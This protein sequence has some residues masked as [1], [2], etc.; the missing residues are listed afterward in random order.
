MMQ[1]DSKVPV[2]LTLQHGSGRRQLFIKASPSGEQEDALQI[3]GNPD[4]PDLTCY[5][6]VMARVS[7]MPLRGSDSEFHASVQ[8]EAYELERLGFAPDEIGFMFCAPIVEK[9]WAC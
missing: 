3:A 5:R 8:L 4:H 9:M 6:E 1:A 2:R 7:F